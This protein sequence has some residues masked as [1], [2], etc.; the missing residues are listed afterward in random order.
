MKSLTASIDNNNKELVKK[1][2]L[3]QYPDISNHDLE[4][5]LSLPVEQK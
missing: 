4:F 5:I 1:K 2:I 3:S